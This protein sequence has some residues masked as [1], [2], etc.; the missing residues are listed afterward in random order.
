MGHQDNTHG[1]AAAVV[2][3]DVDKEKGW[4]TYW[5]ERLVFFNHSLLFEPDMDY[6]LNYQG[7]SDVSPSGIHHSGLDLITLLLRHTNHST[8]TFP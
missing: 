7:Q 6:S 2:E 3:L 5:S 4:C 1:G 8:T